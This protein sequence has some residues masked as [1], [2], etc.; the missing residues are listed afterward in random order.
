MSSEKTTSAQETD[1]K[2]LTMKLEVAARP[3]VPIGNLVGYAS[4]KFNDCFVVE[5]FKILKNEK[6]MFVG[7]PS[8]PDERSDNGYRDTAKPITSE[9]RKVLLEAISAA[10]SAE[11]E[12]LQARAAAVVAPEKQSI[13]KELAEGKKQSK[14]DNANLPAP[15][16]SSKAQD[17]AGR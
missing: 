15:D 11:V 2:A 10:Y 13:Q 14:K 16:K 17:V 3:I 1:S 7:M 12:K 8:R 9:F 6:G 5:G 4:V